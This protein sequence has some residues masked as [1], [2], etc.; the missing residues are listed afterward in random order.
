MNVI[1]VLQIGMHDKIGGVETFL[2]NYYRNINRKMIQFDFINMF[3]KLYYD[4]EIKKLGGKVYN[5]QNVKKNPVSY[6]Q[7]IKK[8]VKENQYNIVHINMLSMANILPIIAAKKGGAKHIIIH[9][10]NTGTPKGILRKILDKLNKSIAIKNATNYFACS[11]LAGKWMFSGKAEFE[12]INNAID[13]E[14]F[15]YNA[16]VRENIRKGLNI[17]NEVIIG[18]IGRFCEQKNHIFLINMF[19]QFCKIDKNSKLLL[20]GEG[21]L[22]EKIILEIQKRK[23]DD[24][25]IILTPKDDIQN[26]YQ[27]MDVF[28]LPSKFE[29]LGIVAIEAQA[30][31]LQCICSD[32]IP[33]EVKLLNTFKKIPLN[34]SEWIDELKNMSCRLGKEES[35]CALQRNSYDIKIEAKKLM[36]K[37]IE[38]TEDMR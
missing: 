16:N 7:A 23:L 5:V 1:R 28:V 12:I 25:V 32:A 18:H 9:S 26:Y 35:K 33:D 6:Y 15:E 21:E 10:H 11:N 20:I 29:G 22:K 13:I 37:Y 24:R 31:G 4:N 27:A 8:I 36:N 34:Y 38:Y 17:K 3:D 14:K 19:E 30:N 2:M